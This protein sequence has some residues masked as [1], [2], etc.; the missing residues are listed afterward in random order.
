[1][2]KPVLIIIDMLEDFFHKGNLK[3]VR[4]ELTNSINQLIGEARKRSIPVLWVR[5]EFEPDLSDAFLAQRKEKILITI[6]GTAGV[7]VLGE[8]DRRSNDLEVIKKRYSAFFKTNLD[9]VLDKIRPSKLILAGVNTHACVRMT[10]ID[11][12]QRDFDVVVVADCVFSN[13]QVHHQV[14][15]EYMDGHICQVIALSDLSQAIG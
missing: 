11:A 8:L 6:K 2:P 1:M 15:L 5:Q 4:L 12:Y 9:E 10:A 13:D 7:N 3:S 14:T